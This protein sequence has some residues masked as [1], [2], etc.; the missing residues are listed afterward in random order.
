MLQGSPFDLVGRPPADAPDDAF[1]VLY[2]VSAVFQGADP[3]CE[4]SLPAIRQVEFQPD[5]EVGGVAA[6]AAPDFVDP[7]ALVQCIVQ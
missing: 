3:E 7:A 2:F 6:G 1:L 5:A 4:V